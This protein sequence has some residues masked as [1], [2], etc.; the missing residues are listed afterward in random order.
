M[1][2]LF[3]AHKNQFI[4]RYALDYLTE[5]LMTQLKLVKSYVKGDNEI[6]PEIRPRH[7]YAFP[8]D[9]S[10]KTHELNSFAFDPSH[11]SSSITTCDFLC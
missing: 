1:D 10:K 2:A 9:P 6:P 11:R 5:G 3:I 8:F 4:Q 7:K